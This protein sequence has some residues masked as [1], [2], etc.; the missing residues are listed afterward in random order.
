MQKKRSKIQ[1]KMAFIA[2]PNIVIASINPICSAII[3]PP[4]RREPPHSLQSLKNYDALALVI[5]LNKY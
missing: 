5:S 2:H 3:T 1:N 4:Q